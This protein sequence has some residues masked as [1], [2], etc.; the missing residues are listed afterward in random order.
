MVNELAVMAF[1]LVFYKVAMS[2][3]N[4]IFCS[5]T[6]YLYAYVNVI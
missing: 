4:L 1:V 3:M 6:D 5:W 2:I